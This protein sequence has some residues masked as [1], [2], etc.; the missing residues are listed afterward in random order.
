MKLLL[1]LF[2][3]QLSSPIL[4]LVLYLMMDIKS[5]IIKVVIANLIGGLIFYNVDKLIFKQGKKYEKEIE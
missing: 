1:Y 5:T 3:W 4:G 2:R